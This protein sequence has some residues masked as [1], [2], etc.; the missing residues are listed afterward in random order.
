M[1]YDNRQPVARGDAE[2]NSITEN[3]SKRKDSAPQRRVGVSTGTQPVIFELN[4]L[5]TTDG[6]E[7]E[8]E[9]ATP[10]SIQALSLANNRVSLFNPLIVPSTDYSIDIYQQNKIEVL[11]RVMEWDFPIFELEEVAGDHILSQ[12]IN[13]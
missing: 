5:D 4:G 10:R 13:Y 6:V 3:G 11:D 2:L 9:L 1:E 8:T 12:V 7:T